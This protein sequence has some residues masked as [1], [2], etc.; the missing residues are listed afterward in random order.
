MIGMN[1]LELITKHNEEEKLNIITPMI[2]QHVDLK[3]TNQVFE[4]W[5]K[6]RLK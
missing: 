3:N 5:W 4:K 6:V 2:G 1:H